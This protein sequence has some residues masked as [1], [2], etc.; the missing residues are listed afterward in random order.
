MRLQPARHAQREGGERAQGVPE[1]DRRRARVVRAGQ[2]RA[3]RHLALRVLRAPRRHAAGD[4][5]QVTPTY[6][7]CLTTSVSGMPALPRA[8]LR[9][10][11]ILVISFL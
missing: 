10:L 2:R 11:Q 6:I 3:R 7:H 8:R 9:D 5:L 1:G 4:A